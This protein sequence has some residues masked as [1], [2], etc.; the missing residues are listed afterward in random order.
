MLKFFGKTAGVMWIDAKDKQVAR[1]EAV[2]AESIK[3]GGGVLAKLN[4][5][6]SFTMEQDRINDEIWLPSQTD[7][8][9][10][11]RILLFKGMNINQ[12]VRSYGY[13][14]FATEVKDAKVNEVKNP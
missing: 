1:I 6:A 12:Q 9:A 13:R 3:I 10:S 14:K 11:A 8:N 4:K 5:G 7:I 2:L